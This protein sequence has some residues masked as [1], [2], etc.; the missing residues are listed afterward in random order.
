MMGNGYSGSWLPIVPLWMGVILVGVWA[1][2]RLAQRGS[3][4]SNSGTGILLA[5]VALVAGAGMWMA[6]DNSRDD[7]WG[8][9]DRVEMHGRGVGPGWAWLAGDG[10][11]VN[12]LAEARDRAEIFAAT[13]GP[14]LE[15]AE[16]MR[17]SNNYYA[18][19]AEADGTL[20]TTALVDPQSGAVHLEFGPATMWNS[21]FAMMPIGGTDRE[22]RPADAH[23]IALRW[24]EQRG[25]TVG[26][27]E[28]FPGHYTLHTLRGG[29]IEGMV[30][31]NA[32]TRVVWPHAWHGTFVERAE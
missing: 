21:R 22:L 12:N 18:E 6:A 15:V 19:L 24:A 11:R 26:A 23:A 14:D 1:V 16:V 25:F 9:W 3:A 29:D 20:V 28:H 17:F 2:P 5:A 13:L 4:G 31:V 32:T 7:P 30:S 10:D 8:P 27:A